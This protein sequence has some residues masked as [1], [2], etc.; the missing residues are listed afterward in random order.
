MGARR[1][2]GVA[3]LR[4]S[5]LVARYAIVAIDPAAIVKI[6]GVIAS[7]VCSAAFDDSDSKIYDTDAAG[8]AC[9]RPRSRSNG[10]R[11]LAWFGCPE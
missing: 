8:V 2:S 7:M 1:L 3:L 9:E 6:I 5:R 11:L 4:A 10:C